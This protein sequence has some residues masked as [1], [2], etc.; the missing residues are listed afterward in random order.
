MNLRL[1]GTV[2]GLAGGLVGAYCSYKAA[3]GPRERRFV[4]WAS[5]AVLIYV[6]SFLAALR[7]L[8]QAK[9]WLWTGYPLLLALGIRYLNRKQSAIRRGEQPNA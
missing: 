2:L 4:V 9:V 6:A 3:S 7:L 1:V 8:P 5:I